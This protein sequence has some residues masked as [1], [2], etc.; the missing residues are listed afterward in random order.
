MNDP[1]K[2]CP[3]KK[4]CVTD[5]TDMRIQCHQYKKYL[6]KFKSISI[7]SKATPTRKRGSE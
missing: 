4:D 6:D 1:C 2:T 5:H 3:M 7:S